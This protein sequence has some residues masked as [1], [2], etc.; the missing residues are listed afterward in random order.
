MSQTD[1][2][3]DVCLQ[4]LTSE[5]RMLCTEDILSVPNS[6]QPL[7]VL[8]R[9]CGLVVRASSPPSALRPAKDFLSKA[10]ALQLSLLPS[11]VERL[12][13]CFRCCPGEKSHC[14][15]TEGSVQKKLIDGLGWNGP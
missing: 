3:A 7:P 8:E 1:G 14:G 12:T 13:H 6:A 2:T 10:P 11:A 15:H 5:R 4:F 9:K